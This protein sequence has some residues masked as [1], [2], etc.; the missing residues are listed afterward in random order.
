MVKTKN[1]KQT[2]GDRAMKYP[3]LQRV[4][5]RAASDLSYEQHAE[6][7]LVA[8][9]AYMKVFHIEEFQQYWKNYDRNEAERMGELERY[10]AELKPSKR[11]PFNLS[12]MKMLQKKPLDRRM[13]VLG[14]DRIFG[15]D[16]LNEDHLRFKPYVDTKKYRNDA[17]FVDMVA[18][19]L[20]KLHS[21]LGSLFPTPNSQ[22]S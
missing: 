13:K 7:H 18:T 22:L 21:K 8:L 16:V 12:A 6:L 4:N 2:A 11:L 17:K 3:Y 15:L 9:R 14:Q 1:S 10:K 20:P 5:R 19:H